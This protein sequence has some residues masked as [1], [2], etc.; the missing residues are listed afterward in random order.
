MIFSK[1]FYL[2]IKTTCDTYSMCLIKI[3]KCVVEKVTK[4]KM[5]MYKHVTMSIM[6]VQTLNVSFI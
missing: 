5:Y 4:P 3:T 1:S 2:K 6:K